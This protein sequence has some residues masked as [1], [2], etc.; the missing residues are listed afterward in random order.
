MTEITDENFGRE[1]LT[2]TGLTIVHLP[3]GAILEDFCTA[4]SLSVADL[5]QKIHVPT[6]EINNLIKHGSGVP[7]VIAEK[8]KLIFQYPVN[9]WSNL[10]SDH[11]D[12]LARIKGN[13]NDINYR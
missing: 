12:D 13:G 1:I 3:P 5:A 11:T 7:I 10:N 2:P 6:E 4:F 8:I 9:F